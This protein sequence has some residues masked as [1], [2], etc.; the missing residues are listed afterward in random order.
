[1]LRAKA[2]APFAHAA[3]LLAVASL[4]ALV[5]ACRTPTSITLEIT[6]D[7]RC[8]D[9]KGVS[10]ASGSREAAENAPPATTTTK[11]TAID[12]R[13]NRIGSLVVVPSAGD[14]AELA[15]RVVAGVDRPVD[16]CDAAR[17][18]EGC[19]VARR[20][21]RFEPHTELKLPI[22]LHL[23]CKSVACDATTTCVDAGCKSAKLDD[24]GACSG[25]GCLSGGDAAVDSG[26]G[27]DAAVD[28]P[29]DGPVVCKA[30]EKKCGDVCAATSDPAYGCTEAGCSPCDPTGKASYVCEGGA[31]KATG[32]AAGLKSCSGSCVAKD[33]AH[34]CGAASCAPCPSDNGVPYCDAGGRCALTCNIGYKLC[35]GV[36]VNVG[37]PNF[38]CGPTTCDKSSCPSPGGGTLICSAGKCVIG[39]CGA[40]TKACGGS[41]VPTDVNNGCGDAARCTACAPGESCVGGPPTTCQCVPESKATTCSK[42]EC[43][44]TT[45]NCGQ[46]VDC[47][48]TCAAPKTCGGG[49]AGNV[50]GCTPSGSPCDGVSCGTMTDSCG[51]SVS[52]GCTGANTCGGGG[53]PGKCGCTPTN[54]CVGGACGT[55]SNGCGGTVA[56]T[57]TGFDTCG[58]GGTPGVCGCTPEPKAMTCSY[59]VCGIEINNCGDPV[60]CGF[61][62][63]NCCGDSC[64]CKTC[65]CP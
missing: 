53:V 46:P 30:G 51:N 8:E 64:V 43:G 35:G 50:C 63:G 12:A 7:A 57:C 39:S 14:D 44:A 38:G 34:G 36:C 65:M 1:M 6:T 5:A 59:L 32:C 56:C 55:L 37:D 16:E 3:A 24:P 29:P 47:G 27:G 10:I 61:C 49:G 21:L 41:C 4:A 9:L 15:I 48:N 45:N 54:P 11:C 33:P 19:I 40:G 22:E 20:L 31:C 58:G 17:G 60:N 42:V 23:D 62:G 2:R 26:D 18:Y 28:A 25:E 13:T 52:C